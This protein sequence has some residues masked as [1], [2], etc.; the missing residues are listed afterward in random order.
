MAGKNL[1]WN[2]RQRKPFLSVSQRQRRLKALETAILSATEAALGTAT[3]LSAE[4][5]RKACFKGGG[6]G[7]L[8]RKS[9]VSLIPRF[10]RGVCL[11]SML[12]KCVLFVSG[13]AAAGC[14]LGAWAATGSSSDGNDPA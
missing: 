12:L 10:G 7:W 2:R 8:R 14:G 5:W 6:Q 13:H 3:E 9:I 4:P 1:A 11:E